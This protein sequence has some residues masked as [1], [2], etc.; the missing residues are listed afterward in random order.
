MRLSCVDTGGYLMKFLQ[1]PIH[2][3]PNNNVYINLR[4]ISHIEDAR[5]SNSCTVYFNSG[6]KVTVAKSAEEVLEAMSENR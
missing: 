6:K 1:A 5:H 3:V 2:A 4:S